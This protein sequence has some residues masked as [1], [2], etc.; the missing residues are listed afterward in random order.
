MKPEPEIP[1]A[2]TDVP[3]LGIEDVNPN[4][5]EIWGDVNGDGKKDFMVDIKT[6]YAKWIL[7]GTVI[8]VGALIAY[9]TA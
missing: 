4:E 8:V 9:F 5:V 1:V 3:T 2:G 7:I 6:K